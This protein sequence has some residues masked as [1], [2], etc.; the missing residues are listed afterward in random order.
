MGSRPSV[1][2]SASD[3][4]IYIVQANEVWLKAIKTSRIT[5]R[6]KKKLVIKHQGWKTIRIFVSSTFKDFH[7]E[8][9]FLVKKVIC[10]HK[11]VY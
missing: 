1:I 2:N 4:D 10:N 5:E 11:P 6:V 7:Q 3:G 8:R 9:E